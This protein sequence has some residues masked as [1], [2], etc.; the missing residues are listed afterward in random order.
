MS[1][2]FEIADASVKVYELPPE[3]LAT[4][5]KLK[6]CPDCGQALEYWHP[7]FIAC[8]S[9]VC[10]FVADLSGKERCTPKDVQE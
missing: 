4:L 1:Q 9:K 7:E 5:P 3:V 8:T 6:P 10:L 2:D